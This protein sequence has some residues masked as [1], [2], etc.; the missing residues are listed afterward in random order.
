MK[1]PMK[2]A[3]LVERSQTKEHVQRF[4]GALEDAE[5]PRITQQLRRDVRLDVAAATQELDE[6]IRGLPEELRAGSLAGDV[7]LQ[8]NRTALI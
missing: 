4:R 8:G 1:E 6:A 5:D 3:T 2:L 7:R